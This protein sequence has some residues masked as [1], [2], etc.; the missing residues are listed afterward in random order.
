MYKF[1]NQSPKNSHACVPLMQTDCVK[2]ETIFFKT[3]T[4]CMG[5]ESEPTKLP[6]PRQKPRR[7]GGLKQIKRC[8]RVLLQVT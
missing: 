6:I 2:L 7:G 5:P 4:L 3:F 8:R 1:Q